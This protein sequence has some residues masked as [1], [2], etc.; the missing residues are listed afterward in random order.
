ML[1]LA[2]VRV[3]KMRQKRR[4]AQR[5][6]EAATPAVVHV[7]GSQFLKKVKMENQLAAGLYDEL[8]KE[9]CDR[10]ELLQLWYR[11]CRLAGLPKKFHRLGSESDYAALSQ[12]QIKNFVNK[13]NSWADEID[14]LNKSALFSPA[15]LLRKGIRFAPE[16]ERDKLLLEAEL[17]ESLPSLLRGYAIRFDSSCRVF[18]STLGPGAFSLFKLGI[19]QLVEFVHKNTKSPKYEILSDMLCAGFAAI[20]PE[21][22]APRVFNDAALKGFYL[23]AAKTYRHFPLGHMESLLDAIRFAASNPR[24]RDAD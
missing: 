2:F 18:R 16:E 8:C 3:N 5:P 14:R 6:R 20:Y 1:Q 4:G 12:A 15:R 9:G 24:S 21:V 22:D 13:V 10:E 11:T 17:L 23:R 19:Y 7:R